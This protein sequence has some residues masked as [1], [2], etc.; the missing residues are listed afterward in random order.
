MMETRRKRELCSTYSPAGEYVHVL[1]IYL[2]YID[3]GSS[4][5]WVLSGLLPRPLNYSLKLILRALK[6]DNASSW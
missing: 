5:Y 1:F 3:W 4:I 2:D 6:V